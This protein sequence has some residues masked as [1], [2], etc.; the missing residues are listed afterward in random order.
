MSLI[1][2]ISLVVAVGT[3]A[4]SSTPMH[5]VSIGLDGPLETHTCLIITDRGDVWSDGVKLE[6]LVAAQRS[7]HGK[8][9]LMTDF[10]HPVVWRSAHAEVVES[11]EGFVWRF[12]LDTHAVEVGHMRLYLHRVS[13]EEVTRL[14][15]PSVS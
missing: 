15:M 2:A 7:S 5:T 4:V 1:F 3:T 11:R 10:P 9:F 13:D 6:S 14:C 12:V 8:T